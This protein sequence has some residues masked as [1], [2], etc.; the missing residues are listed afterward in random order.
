LRI[1]VLEGKKEYET[2]EKNLNSTFS[3]KIVGRYT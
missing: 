3:L 1:S 2:L